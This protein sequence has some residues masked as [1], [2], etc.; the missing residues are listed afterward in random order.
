M[1]EGWLT[2]WWGNALRPEDIIFS[3]CCD[4][5]LRLAL[6]AAAL[7]LDLRFEIRGRE[8][9]IPLRLRYVEI[10]GLRAAYVL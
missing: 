4:K 1:C 10:H 3:I 5:L 8:S 6:A 7:S 2:V 9:E